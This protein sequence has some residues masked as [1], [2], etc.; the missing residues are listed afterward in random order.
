M[1][2]AYNTLA[3]NIPWHQIPFEQYEIFGKVLQHIGYAKVENEVHI[4]GDIKNWD[5]IAFH[6]WNGEINAVTGTPS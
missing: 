5:F 2:A 4:Q 3:L 6:A 1:T